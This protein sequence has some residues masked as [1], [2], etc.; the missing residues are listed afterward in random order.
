[1]C[2]AATRQ[3]Q[4]CTESDLRESGESDLMRLEEEASPAPRAAESA[5]FFPLVFA[6]GIVGGTGEPV[7]VAVSGS[8]ARQED[9]AAYCGYS[10]PR[11]PHVVSSVFNN[12]VLLVL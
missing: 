7:C 9:A 5:R 3:V 1:V 12:S 6:A 8:G 2:E 4:P 11:Q 10:G